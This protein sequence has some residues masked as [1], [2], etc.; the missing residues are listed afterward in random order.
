MSTPDTQQL[1]A[2]YVLGTLS[3]PRRREVQQRLPH[4]AELREAVAFWEARLQPLTELVAPAEPSAAVWQR[5]EASL[6]PARQPSQAPPRPSAWRRW[7]DSV[8]L[9]RGLALAGVAAATFFAV[10]PQVGLRQPEA[11]FMVVLVAPNQTAPGW[12]V[13][14]SADRRLRLVP[15]TATDVP[16]QRSL[17][18]WTKA[19][20]WTA[21]LSLGLVQPGKPLEV[22]L[23]QLPPLQPNQLFE[24]TLEPYNGSPTGRPTGPILY[25]GR[26]VQML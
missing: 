6:P 1:A 5:I 9:W 2:D 13:Q 12:V 16:E 24:I 3:A 19:D 14:T 20:G 7:W 10:A 17:Q 4:D 26:S 15:L 23:D 22:S 18:F 11:R 25:I 8:A 21:P